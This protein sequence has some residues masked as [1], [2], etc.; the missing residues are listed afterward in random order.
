MHTLRLALE[1]LLQVASVCPF[2]VLDP[3]PPTLCLFLPFFAM[4]HVRKLAPTGLFLSFPSSLLLHTAV[5]PAPVDRCGRR[6][7]WHWKAAACACG[8]LQPLPGV[9]LEGR[10]DV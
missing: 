5:G 2:A 3:P 1:P 7:E 10:C 8:P 9:A 4:A 6:Q